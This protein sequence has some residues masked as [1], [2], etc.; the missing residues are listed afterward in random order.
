[1]RPLLE[2]AILSK[3][4]LPVSGDATI[5]TARVHEQEFFREYGSFEE[6]PHV[7]GRLGLNPLYV[8]EKQDSLEASKFLQLSLEKNI[9]N[10]K[11][12]CPRA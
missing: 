3:K 10:V 1:M 8:E 7:E 5:E 12:I 2:R 11:S 9:R 6:W 4:F